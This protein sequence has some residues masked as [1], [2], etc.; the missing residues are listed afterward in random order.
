VTKYA[1][2]IG[3][4]VALMLG[5]RATGS[6]TWGGAFPISRGDRALDPVLAM[7]A[8]GDLIVVWDQQVGDSCASE[9][10]SLSCSHRVGVTAATAGSGLWR[11][12][13]DIARP[14]VGARPQAAIG[15]SGAAAALW[16]H[17]IG[18]DRVVQA[19]Y[20]STTSQ[21]PSWPEPNDLSEAVLEV[22]DHAI[23]IDGAGNAIA[24]WAERTA[25]TFAVR[26]ATRSAQQGVWGAPA[27]LSTP[28]V[29]VSGG[30]SLAVATTGVGVV[31]WVEGGATRASFIRDLHWQPVATLSRSTSTAIGTPSAALGASGDALVV[32]PAQR[33]SSIAVEGAFWTH[34]AATWSEPVEIG[35]LKDSSE[36]PRAAVDSEGNTDVTW[37]GV[38]GVQ[39]AFR[40]VTTGG[41]SRP[42]LV[43]GPSTATTHVTV[44]L[45]E[46]GNRVALWQESGRVLAALRPG[47][48]GSWQPPVELFPNGSMVGNVAL[49]G[50]GRGVAVWEVISGDRVTVLSK[51]L[52]GKGPILDRVVAPKRVVPVGASTPFSVRAAPWAAPLA[53]IPQWTFGDASSASGARVSHRYA[54][55]GRFVA[56]VSQADA[57]SDSS[58]TSVTIR[59]AAR[60]RNVRRP[61]V[62]GAPEVGGTLTC[63]RG[64]WSGS[65]PVAFTYR[66]RRDGTPIPGDAVSRRHRVVP[67][68]VGSRLSCVVTAT[69]AVGA[70]RAVSRAVRPRP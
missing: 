39:S 42:A 17:D 70:E 16:V 36:T 56:T 37:V 59:V 46:S 63:R 15:P 47:A 33:G 1:L 32:W 23:A 24:A 44:G 3:V 40:P 5:T 29:N 22:R 20:V 51:E 30:P 49:T 8:A 7:T 18:R 6:P 43:S 12:P 48:T 4:V 52:D 13:I 9:P 41:W 19:S 28:T 45:Q 34:G 31:A 65:P 64:T 26:A 61:A 50:E 68:D 54:R 2:A 66:W 62:A 27:R 35:V 11:S 53:G 69:N 14:G 10:A 55:P 38:Q 58:T 21:W 57:R 67:R 25:D 60:M